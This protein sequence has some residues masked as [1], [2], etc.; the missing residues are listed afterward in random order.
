MW[1]NLDVSPGW[2]LDRLGAS[3]LMAPQHPQRGDLF[4]AR[5]LWGGPRQERRAP[6]AKSLAASCGRPSSSS[7]AGLHLNLRFLPASST[8]LEREQPPFSKDRRPRRAGPGGTR[9]GVCSPRQDLR[10]AFISEP[11]TSRGSAPAPCPSLQTGS[12]Q[13]VHAHRSLTPS[14]AAARPGSPPAAY[15]NEPRRV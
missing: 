9:R 14:P 10:T 12:S 3:P 1:Q 4:T 2:W 5:F 13:A 11:S 15:G 7:T 8:G 6:R